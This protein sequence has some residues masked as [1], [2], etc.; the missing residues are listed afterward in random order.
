LRDRIVWEPLTMSD[1]R[2]G[3]KLRVP[4][5]FDRLL[6]SIVPGLQVGVASP[7]GPCRG[8]AKIPIVWWGSSTA[9]RSRTNVCPAA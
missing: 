6:T 3:Y 8:H 2:P 9:L 5:A 4:I 1:G 7:K